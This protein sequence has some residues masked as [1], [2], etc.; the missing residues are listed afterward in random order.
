MAERVGFSSLATRAPCQHAAA[1]LRW[2]NRVLIRIEHLA[3]VNHGTIKPE[4][5]W[6]TLI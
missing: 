1:R 3:W 2:S 5:M 6:Q 4:A